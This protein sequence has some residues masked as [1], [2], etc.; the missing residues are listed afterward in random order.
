MA[1]VAIY[2]TAIVPEWIDYNGHLRDAYYGLIVSFACDALMDRVGLDAAYRTRTRCTL[3]TLEMHLHYLREVKGS[4]RVAVAVTILGS[5]RKRLHAGFTLRAVGQLEPAATAELMLLHVRQGDAPGSEPFPAPI[6][7]A[8]AALAASTPAAA[9]GPSSRAL[10]LS[11]GA[12]K[13]TGS[14]A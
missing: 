11:G 7:A 6:A 8:L 3:Y 10:S 1:G 13:Q 12:R 14:G 4:E 9:F 2:E 5:D